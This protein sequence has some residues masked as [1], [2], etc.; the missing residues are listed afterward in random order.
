MNAASTAARRAASSELWILCANSITRPL[1]SLWDTGT[2]LATSCV[3]KASSSGL[4]AFRAVIAFNTLSL[5]RRAVS[6][7]L[8]APRKSNPS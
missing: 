8:A 7:G 1:A 4:K 3:K 2:I 5:S 6:S